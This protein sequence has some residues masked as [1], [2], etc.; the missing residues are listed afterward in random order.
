MTVFGHNCKCFLAVY[1]G[2]LA[3]DGQKMA[4]TF[5]LF[6]GVQAFPLSYN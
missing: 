1:G 4:V 6:C 5:Q 3:V 2:I